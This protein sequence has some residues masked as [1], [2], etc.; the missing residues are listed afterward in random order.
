[1]KK[2]FGFLKNSSGATAIEYAII[3]GII[4]VSLIAVSRLLSSDI[5]AVFLN[6][7]DQINPP[8]SSNP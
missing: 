1:M 6:I 3:A 8:V 7:G 5:G 2:L 4:G